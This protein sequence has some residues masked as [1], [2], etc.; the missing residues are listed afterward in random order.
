MEQAT[1]YTVDS[2]GQLAW[3]TGN[4]TV[5]SSSSPDNSAHCT[6]WSQYTYWPTYWVPYT[7]D[8]KTGAAFKV[9]QK[10]MEKKLVKVDDN[11]E[12]FCK[13]VNAIAE[14]L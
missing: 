4:V 12:K 7:C 10:L 13:L 6:P 2:N 3:T 9:A 1:I 11:V 14:A 8:D 5:G